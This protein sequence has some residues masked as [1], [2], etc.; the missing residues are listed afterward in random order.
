M[1]ATINTSQV[2]AESKGNGQGSVRRSAPDYFM[3]GLP[4]LP[5]VVVLSP[6]SRGADVDRLPNHA[7]HHLYP[8]PVQFS[9]RIRLSIIKS[10]WRRQ[11]DEARVYK[12]P[13]YGLSQSGISYC[14]HAIKRHRDLFAA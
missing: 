7:G 4:D 14:L 1:R 10:H 6:P 3:S 9:S 13:E 8:G 5:G 11:L 2:T 12:R